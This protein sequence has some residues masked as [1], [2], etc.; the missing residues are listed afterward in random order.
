MTSVEYGVPQGSV[1]GPLLFLLFINDIEFATFEVESRLFADDTSLILHCKN[2][3][4]LEILSKRALNDINNWFSCNK[5][6][7]SIEK[8]NFI[9][10]HGKKMDARRHFDR[11]YLGQEYIPRVTHTKY[12]GLIFDEKLTWE[13]HI[14]HLCKSLTK[15]FSIFYNIRQLININLSRTI[16][17]ACI[18]SRLKYGIEV[19]GSA[20]KGRLNKLQL[21]QN[22]LLKLLCRKD[23]MYS[24]NQ[25]Y[26]DLNILKVSDI[27]KSST[28]QFVFNCISGNTIPKFQDYYTFRENLYHHNTRQ[29]KNL[30]T[31]KIRTETGRTTTHY[32]GATLW[33]NLNRDLKNV[34]SPYSFKKYIF[35]MYLSSYTV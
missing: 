34:D 10:F 5:L 18:F 31:H 9:L 12:I 17:Y 32:S 22:K 26:I 21:M 30:N 15:Y 19:Y 33:N 23:Q 35:Q 1:L 11:L 20:T 29:S 8:S 14:V 2:I 16:Y 7:L 27:Y 25:L 3:N 28:L 6:S 4:D 24:I 13:N